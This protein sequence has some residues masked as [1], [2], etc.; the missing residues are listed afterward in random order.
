LTKFGP[1]KREPSTFSVGHKMIVFG[2]IGIYRI[3]GPKNSTV[4]GPRPPPWENYKFYRFLCFFTVL[5]AFNRAGKTVS[6]IGIYALPPQKRRFYSVGGQKLINFG[7]GMILGPLMLSTE[8]IRKRKG[9][10]VFLFFVFVS[11]RIG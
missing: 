2:P 11:C 7:F 6:K 9:K 3:T 8:A 4:L 10:T 1:K 5:G